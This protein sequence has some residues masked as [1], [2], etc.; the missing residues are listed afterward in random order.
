MITSAYQLFTT[1]HE[2][3]FK[4]LIKTIHSNFKK[5]KNIIICT[6]TILGDLTP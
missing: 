5:K 6:T 2:T 1:K 4:K 3:T